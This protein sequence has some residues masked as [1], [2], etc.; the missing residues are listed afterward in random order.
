[1]SDN[2]ITRGEFEASM[3]ALAKSHDNHSQFMRDSMSDLKTTLT[4]IVE[5]QAKHTTKIERN[6]NNIK[7]M[8][9]IF[10]SIQ[11]AVIAI[12]GYFYK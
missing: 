12:V 11:T 8:G 6:S 3:K 5:T 2:H 7:W 9:R 1:M 10:S 4:P